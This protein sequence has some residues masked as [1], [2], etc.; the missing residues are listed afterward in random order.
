MTKDY[1]KAHIE[2]KKAQGLKEIRRL[3]ALPQNEQA[4]RDYAAKL[5]ARAKHKER[6]SEH[7]K[8]PWRVGAYGPNGCYTVGTEGGLMVAMV[9]H[10][11]NYPDQAE[12]AFGDANLIA[13]A[14]D[15]LEALKE[16][17]ADFGDTPSDRFRSL[18]PARAAIAKAQG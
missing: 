13:A 8:G 6:M 17:V 5:N 11:V 7:T 3:W 16:M 14:P 12:Q 2:A 10:S 4:I 18:G 1:L 15:L 9:A